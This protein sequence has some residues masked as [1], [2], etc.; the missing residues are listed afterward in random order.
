[1]NNWYYFCLEASKTMLDINFVLPRTTNWDIRAFLHPLTVMATADSETSPPLSSADLSLV[2]KALK[3]LEKLHKLCTDPQLGLR[4]SPPYLPD[5]M[6]ETSALLVQVWEPYSGC[7]AAGGPGP[8]GDEA[9]Y[10]RIHI[11]NLLDK[12]NRAVLLFR[13]GRE[14]I[15]EETSSYRWEFISIK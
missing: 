8:R 9:K 7:M 6:S 10:L 13:Q 11:R 2:H 15:F 1:M 5:L 14:R 12:A 3:Q 4:N